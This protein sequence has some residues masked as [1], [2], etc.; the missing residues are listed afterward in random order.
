[1]A[2]ATAGLAVLALWVGMSY[3]F[4]LVFHFHPALVGGAAGWAYRRGLGRPGR[5]REVVALSVTTA[6][7]VAVGAAVI[8]A[9]GRGL[10]AAWF[11]G[12]VAAA[13]LAMGLVFLTRP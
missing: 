5:R 8:A 11:V 4:D 2:A 7:L 13:G 3:G 1:M 10:D 12:L 6:A 9:G